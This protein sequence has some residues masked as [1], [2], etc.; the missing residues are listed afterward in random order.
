MA[1]RLLRPIVCTYQTNL[2]GWKENPQIIIGF[3]V[4]TL[5]SAKSIEYQKETVA[6]SGETFSRLAC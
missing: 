2:F 6:L 4:K 5:L 3:K 1:P